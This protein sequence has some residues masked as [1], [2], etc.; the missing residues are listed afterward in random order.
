MPLVF[1]FP[2]R[3]RRFADPVEPDNLAAE[4]APQETA[5]RRAFLAAV[6]EM[7]VVLDAADTRNGVSAGTLS[8]MLRAFDRVLTE[9]GQPVLGEAFTR[10]AQFAYGKLAQTATVG[11]TFD[12]IDPEAVLWSQIHSATMVTQVSD[13]TRRAIRAAITRALSL[14]ADPRDVARQIERLI[15]LTERDVLAVGNLRT[16]LIEEGRS[17]AQIER[18]VTKYA[19]RLLRRRAETIAIHETMQAANRGQEALWANAVRDGLLVE[20]EWERKWIVARDERTCKLCRP[21]DG[22]RAPMLGGSFEGGVLYPP[23]HVRCRC[24]TGLVRKR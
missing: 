10:G 20:S 15:G 8:D 23:R 12:L 19:N 14:G 4:V 2:S 16:R 1:L 17:D 18:M 5:M 21:L 11:Y 13:E 3:P 22:K 6:R 24:V 9:R 7:L